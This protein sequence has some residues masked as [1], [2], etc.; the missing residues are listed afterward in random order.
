[1]ETFVSEAGEHKDLIHNMQALAMEAEFLARHGDFHAAVKICS[2]LRNIYD[3]STHSQP[4]VKFYLEDK[5]IQCIALCAGWYEQISQLSEAKEVCKYVIDSLSNLASQD[6]YSLFVTLY[7]VVCV[8][9]DDEELVE[10]ARNV[11]YKHV[12]CN[13]DKGSSNPFR[14]IKKPLQMLLDL[15]VAKGDFDS[16]KKKTAGTWW[17]LGEKGKRMSTWVLGEGGQPSQQPINLFCDNLG[18]NADAVKAEL[19]LELAASPSMN[20]FESIKEELTIKAKSLI[21]N[22]LQFATDGGV[23]HARITSFTEKYN[24]EC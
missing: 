19:C 6:S 1:M 18:L 12:A 7:P 2:E 4:L 10:R 17:A 11:F 23:S 21:K 3:P 9:K 20:T 16:E 8:M 13:A 24:V 15:A 5:C 22:A 14:A